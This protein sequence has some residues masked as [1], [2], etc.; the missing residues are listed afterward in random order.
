MASMRALVADRLG[1]GV[2]MPRVGL[3]R[4]G[5]LPRLNVC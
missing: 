3:K 5:P 4:I 2:P 1:L